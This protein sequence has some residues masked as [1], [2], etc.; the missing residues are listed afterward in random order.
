MDTVTRIFE[1]L[2]STTME[3]QEFARLV[4]V[5]DDT[6]SNWRRR[7]SGSYTKYLTQIADVLET[8]VEYLLTGEKEK[9]ATNT[10]K[11][12]WLA[13]FDSLTPESQKEVIAFI[14]FKAAQEDA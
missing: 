6:A 7:K 1:L 3:Q 9:P 14:E 12:D 5:S 8:T 4:G 10:D 2:D 11:P 13:R